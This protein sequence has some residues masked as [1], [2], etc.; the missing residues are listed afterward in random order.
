M[1]HKNVLQTFQ[2]LYVGIPAL[3]NKYTNL[4]IIIKCEFEIKKKNAKEL[5][6]FEKMTLR[7]C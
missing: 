2:T 4:L 5:N 3:G 7:A 1:W 6:K